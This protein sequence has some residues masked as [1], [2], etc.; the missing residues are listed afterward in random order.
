MITHDVINNGLHELF[1]RRGVQRLFSS[2]R[3]V[4]LACSLIPP[5]RW[6]SLIGRLIRR[7]ASV[8]ADVGWN[9]ETLR[10][11]HLPGLL[12]GMD[13]IFPNAAEAKAMTGARTVESAAKMLAGWVQVPVVKL[14]QSGSLAVW[15]G[16]V[17]RAK[18]LRVRSVDATGSGDAF[19]GGFLHG[20]LAGWPIEDCLR[21]GNVCGAW[22][23]ST[24]GGSSS[25]PTAKKLKE[26]MNKI[27]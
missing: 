3:H 17:V 9:P 22:A 19:N 26:L 23:A 11:A 27:R 5:R 18:P 25:I 7:G 12:G 20:Y 1:S 10:S 13:F 15:Q 14:G 6:L 8:S 4:H 24:A 16:R 2:A 21:A